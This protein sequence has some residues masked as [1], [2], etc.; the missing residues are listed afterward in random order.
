MSEAPKPVKT[1]ENLALDGSNFHSWKKCMTIYLEHLGV[2]AQVDGTSPRPE[3]PAA[4]VA[5]TKSDSTAKSQITFNIDM[6]LMDELDTQTACTMW[7]GLVVRFGT[8]GGEAVA[9]ADNALRAKKVGENERLVDHF[10]A[11]RKLK[12]NVTNMGGT[13]PLEQ[14]RTIVTNSLHGRW[15]V[16]RPGLFNMTNGEQ[17][18][19]NL[20]LEEQ[21]LIAC[22]DLKFIT[23]EEQAL[24][25][26]IARRDNKR[27]DCGLPPK[28]DHCKKV[29]HQTK[30]CYAP[31]GEGERYA[32]AWYLERRKQNANT[33]TTVPTPAASNPSTPSASI[34][35]F[36]HVAA[37]DSANPHVV[38]W[39]IDSGATAH[40][41]Y[42]RHMFSTY[43]TLS[44]PINISGAN[45][46]TFQAIGQGSICFKFVY[47][48][49]PTVVT[50]HNVLYAPELSKNLISV[51]R[52]LSGTNLSVV[53]TPKSAYIRARDRL[54]FRTIGFGLS[55][56][57]DDLYKAHTTVV[58][59][60]Y[61]FAGLVVAQ[62]SIKKSLIEWHCRLGHT[63]KQRL[64]RMKQHNAVT[65]FD[66]IT[67][68]PE[69][70]Q[71][72]DEP[73]PGCKPCIQ[74]KMTASPSPARD[75][76]ATHPFDVIHSDI[77]Y[78]QN[79]SFNKSTL[80]LK[81]VDEHS[82]YVWVF[83]IVK[84]DADT[85]LGAFRQV[86]S[87]AETQFGKRIKSFH[88]DN[89]TEYTNAKFQTYLRD[90]GI[91]FSPSSPDR[92]EQNGIAERINRTGS[93]AVRAMLFGANLPPIYWAE[94]YCLWGNVNNVTGHSFL[95]PHL[96]PYE[97]LYGRKPN[98]AHFRKFGSPCY[99]R[100]P[101]DQRGKLDPKAW[102]GI[103]VGVY[104]DNAYKILVP[105]I[106]IKK[107][108]DVVF[109]ED[110]S[111]CIEPSP[112]PAPTTPSSTPPTKTVLPL[113]QSTRVSIPT[114]RLIESREQESQLSH[115]DNPIALTAQT[116]R[117]VRGIKI[118][119]SWT[120]AMRTP[121]ADEWKV[122]AKYEMGKLEEHNV[123]DMVNQTPD[124]HVIRGRW[125]FNIKDHPDGSLEYRT[126]WVARGDYQLDDE[127]GELFANS[128]DYT[129]ARFVLSLSSDPDATL[130]VI[131][132][133][134]AFLHSPVDETIHVEYPH[135]Q[136]DSK[137]QKL[138]CHLRKALYGLRQGPRA[139]QNCLLDKLSESGFVQLKAAPSAFQLDRED[140]K[141]IFTSHVDDFTGVHFAKTPDDEK[142]RYLDLIA[143]FF[144]FKAKDVT[145]TINHL[146]WQLR[147]LLSPDDKRIKISV[148]SKI[149]VLLLKY[150][151]SDANPVK[152]PL[153]LNI[154]SMD[155]TPP[156]EDKHEDYLSII[157]ALMWIATNAR[158]DIAFAAHFLSRVTANPSAEHFA[159][160]KR[161]LR[162]LKDTKDLGLVYSH[163]APTGTMPVGYCDADLG[164]DPVHRKSVSGYVFILNG[165]AISW[166]CAKQ[167]VVAQSTG[168]AE[169]LSVSVAAREALWFRH[170]YKEIGFDP[171]TTPTTIF[172]DSEI[173]INMTKNAVYRSRTKHINLAYHHIRDEVAQGTV[174]VIHISGKE[175]P[176]DIFTK[177]LPAEAHERIVRQLGLQ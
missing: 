94:A 168:E 81:F 138:V 143:H 38:G 95:P 69:T 82:G 10:A 177:P 6:A 145:T 150:G 101:P 111:R 18:I 88:S 4:L 33:V 128:G 45:G 165:A 100:I 166:K 171:Q 72:P 104:G 19:T 85:V 20:M 70:P 147:L 144:K 134:S 93:D 92:H 169:Y 61:P 24:R 51:K 52:L 131:D 155:L 172:S 54:G 59:R 84:K 7:N 73:T 49:K 164:G 60:K 15:A 40:M 27:G 152:T 89:G 132:I 149:D 107:S 56:D 163:D 110:S 124:M 98:V 80:C 11:L 23:P 16:Y 137:N 115:L 39:Y 87:E 112:T 76:R 123:W 57:E 47:K 108:C 13:V 83:P 37:A 126:R 36:A 170:L 176:A 106:G 5:W 157:G 3:D 55:I 160:A 79:E 161:V 29:G 141:T 43:T 86:D 119:N 109:D 66:F 156:T 151:L 44:T 41:T 140:N 120:E 114:T 174:S 32:P 62:K 75:H 133:N 175:N 21:C 90:R 65:G 97:I 77:E 135:G 99:V 162:Y 142:H 102:K 17:I 50:V 1:S 67:E 42:H 127:F 68:T 31:G 78:M 158:P 118:P 116:P 35:E 146:G 74:G 148:E 173:A 71:S 129:T 25:A 53:F 48:G 46:A 153:P 136:L 8:G 105:G 9:V 96:T 12:A 26:E 122:A 139:W 121:Q 167:N 58:D 117:Y 154:Y 91:V 63:S 30:R 113:R 2:M 125:V 159:L 64:L 34:V 103:F 28:C 130:S 22:G 14:W